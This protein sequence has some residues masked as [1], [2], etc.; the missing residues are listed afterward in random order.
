MQMI[1]GLIF[2]AIFVYVGVNLEPGLVKFSPSKQQC[3]EQ[4]RLN[5]G[6]LRW[7]SRAKQQINNLWACVTTLQWVSLADNEKVWTAIKMKL[8]INKESECH[9]GYNYDP[10]L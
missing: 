8:Q 3:L 6:S 2:A 5:G 1:L 10:Y 4:T 9:G 7:L